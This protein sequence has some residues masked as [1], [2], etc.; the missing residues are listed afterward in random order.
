MNTSIGVERF[1]V[2]GRVLELDFDEFVLL[3]VY[4][5]NGE[6][7][8]QGRLAYKL[9]FY[10]ALF[11]H[12]ARLRAL[13]RKLVVCGDYNTAHT[14]LDLARPNEN[15][16]TSGFMPVEREKLDAIVAQG[17]VDTFRE[18]TSEGGHYSWWSYRR[19]ACERNVGW[20]ID[21][22][23]ITSELRSR[24]VSASIQSDVYGSDHCPVKLVLDV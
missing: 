7:A 14:A 24:L 9:E 3:N 11:E 12:C 20:R 2:E 4:F 17:Y 8:E 23:F 22:H 1:D 6:N 19:G 15:I 21:Y 16:N 13:G 10:D 18:V 5:P